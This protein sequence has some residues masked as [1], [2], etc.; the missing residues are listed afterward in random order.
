MEL[1]FHLALYMNANAFRT[2]ESKMSFAI[3]FYWF[4][5][6]QTSSKMRTSL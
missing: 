6:D 4:F 5:M 2:M 1:I 3:E